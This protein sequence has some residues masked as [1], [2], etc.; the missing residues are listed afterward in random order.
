MQEVQGRQAVSNAKE[1]A[2]YERG[3]RDGYERALQ[4][5]CEILDQAAAEIKHEEKTWQMTQQV[6]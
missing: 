1:L 4:K 6:N 2:A 5:F 3:L